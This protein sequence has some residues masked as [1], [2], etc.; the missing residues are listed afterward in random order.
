MGNRYLYIFFLSILVF[1]FYLHAQGLG[2]TYFPIVQK[3]FS[4]LSH[5]KISQT[6]EPAKTNSLTL[7]VPFQYPMEARLHPEIQTEQKTEIE[8][9]TIK[10]LKIIA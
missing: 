10:N 3:P 4:E 8:S 7:S 1:G 2:F 5:W 9:K 6:F